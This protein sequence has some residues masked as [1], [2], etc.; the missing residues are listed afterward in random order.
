MP[1]SSFID[2][3][4]AV[5]GDLL[6][7]AKL[8]QDS[9]ALA[10]LLEFYRPM[11]EKM[12]QRR[13]ARNL[14]GK[15]SP[16]EVTQLT[17]ISASQKFS[18]FRGE[19]V[20]QFRAWLC[21]ILEHALTDQMRRYLAGCRDTSRET[22]LPSDIVETDLQRPSQICS[23]Q[24]QVMKI[25]RIV[26][27]MPADLRTIV[28]MRYQQDLAFTEIASYLGLSPATVQRRWGVAVKHIARAMA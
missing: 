14:N 27:N 2:S 3:P 24:E 25:M 11:L 21:T 26:E 15:V 5:N 22:S 1:K 10:E 4:E 12:S 17:I 13:M 19:C 16:S 28:R 9:H 18:D 20:Q 6:N 8:S 23:T 7:R